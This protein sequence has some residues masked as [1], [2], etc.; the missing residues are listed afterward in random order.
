MH[1]IKISEADSFYFQDR[2]AVFIGQHAK[3]NRLS[4]QLSINA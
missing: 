3:L 2:L 4:G 1:E